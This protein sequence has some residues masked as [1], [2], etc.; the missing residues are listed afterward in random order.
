MASSSPSSTTTAGA[1]DAITA[2]KLVHD[3]RVKRVAI[4]DA[5]ALTFEALTVNAVTRK[6]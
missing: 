3:G 4:A 1:S 6:R 5:K 2:L